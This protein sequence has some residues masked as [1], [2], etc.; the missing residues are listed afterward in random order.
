MRKITFLL[1]LFVTSLGYS[2]APTT[3]APTPPARVATDV[4]SIYGGGNG[5]NP[6]TDITGIN[7]A[8]NWG[9]PGP[10]T[11]PNPAADPAGMG[12]TVLFYPALSYQGTDFAG[13]AQNASGMEFLHVD[14][15]T[16]GGRTIKITPING[17]GGGTGPGEVLVNIPTTAGQWV[18]VD[19]PKASF[20]GMTWDR[21]FQ[22]KIETEGQ[23]AVRE[24][25][26]LDN[27]YFW[28]APTPAGSDASLTDLRV[29]NVTVPGFIPSAFTYDFEVVIGTTPANAPQITAATTADSGASRV[30]NQATAIPG[31]ATVVVTSQ[32]GNVTQTYT[33]R[34]VATRPVAS[35]TPPTYTSHLAV[36]QDIVDTGNFNNFWEPDDFFGAAPQRQDLDPSATVNK[37]ARLALNVGWGGGITAGGNLTTTNVSMYNT[38]HLDY[39]IPS[40][41]A[42]GT[43]GHQFYLDLISRTNNANTEAFYGVGAA[44]GGAGSGVVDQLIVFDTWVGLDIPMSVFVGKG[45][46]ANNFFQFKIGAESDLNTQLGYFDNLYFYDSATLST[47]SLDLATFSVYPNPSNQNWTVSGSNAEITA[48]Q[49]FDLSGKLVINQN[50]GAFTTQLDGS[51]LT[52]GMYIARISSGSNVQTVKLIKE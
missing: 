6:Y 23:A 16:A 50:V 39:F 41:V 46:N 8:P 44:I 28:K 15:W 52:S 5:G 17:G 49:V 45:F 20:T 19:L 18:S 34:F 25:V 7:Y 40:S 33:V 42:A 10:Y 35:P 37:A 2:Q 31:N 12:N 27:I 47:G 43:R 24:D 29:D 32:N 22:L 4:I 51:A 26:Y 36:I 14:I 48:V 3:N 1:I 30:I 11:P 9:Q 21:V 13:N 38:V